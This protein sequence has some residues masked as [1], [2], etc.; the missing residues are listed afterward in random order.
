MGGIITIDFIDMK[1]ASNRTLLY[2]TMV[3]LMKND[4]AKHTIL[5]VN[6]FGLIQITRQR[7]RQ[8][9]IIDTTEQCPTCHGTG[10][11]KPTI[12]IEEEIQNMIEYLIE[13]QIEKKFSIS[14]HPIVHAYLTRGLISKR[15]KWYFKYKHWIDIL[16]NQNHHLL[17][18]KFYNK[19]ME[20][21]VF[22]TKP[23][24]EE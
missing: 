22:W 24:I 18:F 14:V 10:K 3:T 1:K 16:P 2:Q 9:T 13:K 15:V 19:D 20:Q 4:K 5:P 7:V 17:E 23:N 21:I 12:L 11:V 8:A 6:K